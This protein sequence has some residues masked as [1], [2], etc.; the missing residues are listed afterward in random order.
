M[1]TIDY[2]SI[3]Y[4]VMAVVI[5]VVIASKLGGPQSYRVFFSIIAGVFWPIPA[6]LALWLYIEGTIINIVNYLTKK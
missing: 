6:A 5:A 3:A 2:I 4:M 1:R